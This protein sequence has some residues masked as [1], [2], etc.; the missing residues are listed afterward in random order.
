MTVLEGSGDALTRTAREVLSVAEHTAGFSTGAGLNREAFLK[1]ML[2]IAGVRDI[3]RIDVFACG[4]PTDVAL[5]VVNALFREDGPLAKLRLEHLE[6][7]QSA[8]R[9]FEVVR[10]AL[11]ELLGWHVLPHHHEHAV[12]FASVLH[13]EDFEQLSLVIRRDLDNQENGGHAPQAVAKYV[14][15]IF[16]ATL[17]RDD[18]VAGYFPSAVCADAVRRVETVVDAGTARLRAFVAESGHAHR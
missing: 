8:V 7:E 18:A 12:R 17:L 4:W 14:V 5:E 11:F 15:G 2:G 9:A 1:D 10:V 13:G 16:V 6:S 3:D